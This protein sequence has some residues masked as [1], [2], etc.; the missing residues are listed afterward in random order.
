MFCVECGKEEIFK[1]GVC[2]ECYLKH[3]SFTKGPEIIDIIV[4][5]SCSSYKYKNTWFPESLDKTIKRHIRDAFQ[6]SRELKEVQIKTGY[7]EKRRNIAC[8]VEISGLLED[9][10]IFEQHNLI[11][12][13]KK[14][15]S[16]V[17]NKKFGGYFEAVIQL[18]AEKRKPSRDELRIIRET[19]ETL[20]ENLQLKGY[21][22]LFITDVIEEQGGIDF[23]LSEKGSAFNIAK[24]IQDCFGGEI[25][26]S[27]SNAGMKDSRQ[28][29]RMTYLLRLPS[30]RI[31]DFILYNKSFFHILSI[32]KNKVHVL[33]LFNWSERVFNGKDIQKAHIFGG[34]ERVKEMILV[35]QSKDEVQIM[36]P[37]SYKTFEVRKPRNVTLNQKMINVVTL[38]DRIFLLPEKN[39][40][41]K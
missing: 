18:R 29:F 3:T 41:D 40:I 2:I 36:D 9:K 10:K 4:C 30:Y 8:N 32:N 19:I 31:G 25:K 37:R 35:S 38:D 13:L 26:Q 23:Y 22:G 5:T 1:D 15:I 27:S 28:I 20:V 33:E 34:S 24:K 17:C 7:D 39:T 6:V 12:R 21:R 16:D 14:T 11:V